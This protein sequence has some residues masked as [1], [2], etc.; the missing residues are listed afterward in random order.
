MVFVIAL[1]DALFLLDSACRQIVSKQ[2]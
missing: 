1:R 2:Q